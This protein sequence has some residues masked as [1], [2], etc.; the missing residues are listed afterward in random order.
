M[1][2]YQ[3][4]V[5]ALRATEPSTISRRLPTTWL[6]DSPPPR[7]T[8]RFVRL[9]DDCRL[10]RLVPMLAWRPRSPAPLPPAPSR[11][12]EHRPNDPVARHAPRP[13][14]RCVREPARLAAGSL[15]DLQHAAP[16]AR[17]RRRRSRRRVSRARRPSRL[18][19]T[20]RDA[21]YSFAAERAALRPPDC[22]PAANL[23]IL[24]GSDSEGTERDEPF[25]ANAPRAINNRLIF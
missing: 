2:L 3:V 23:P 1:T 25:L 19:D 6:T 22:S 11:P 20:P 14:R 7:S 4:A 8:R 12:R 5:A 13:S 18:S 10:H 16:S 24:A 21:S 9:S 15:R 17:E